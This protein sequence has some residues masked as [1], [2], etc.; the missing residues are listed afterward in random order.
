MTELISRVLSLPAPPDTAAEL[1]RDILATMSCHASPTRTGRG[2]ATPPGHS[3]YPLC[4]G[5]TARSR[6]PCY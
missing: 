4:W 1:V 3:N 2:E 6:L 5:A